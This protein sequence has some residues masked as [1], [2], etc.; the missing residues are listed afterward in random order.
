MLDFRR[1][2]VGGH[3]KLQSRRYDIVSIS[4][5]STQLSY[6]LAPSVHDLGSWEDYLSSRVRPYK[7]NSNYSS[8]GSYWFRWTRRFVKIHDS[9]RVRKRHRLS[10]L[11]FRY[12][13]EKVLP[14]QCS[15]CL[16]ERIEEKAESGE[17]ICEFGVVRARKRL[18]KWVINCESTLPDVSKISQNFSAASSKWDTMSIIHPKLNI[19][20]LWQRTYI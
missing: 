16:M 8:D 6:I 4:P 17:F 11:F 1:M 14:I 10:F 13:L 19:I 2:K 7:R 5:Q 18:Q 15:W 20:I 9:V 12:W 3:S